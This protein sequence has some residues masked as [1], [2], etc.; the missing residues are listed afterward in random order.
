MKKTAV[1]VTLFLIVSS[2]S[3][4][5]KNEATTSTK[6][7]TSQYNYVNNWSQEQCEQHLKKIEEK[8][9]Y[10]NEHPKEKEQAENEGWFE[11]TSEEKKQV[12]ARLKKLHGTKS[13][14]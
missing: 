5:Q 12:E 8:K 14:K 6:T 3:F 2:L 10:F 9:A 4:A 1:V 7:S 11:K 13:D